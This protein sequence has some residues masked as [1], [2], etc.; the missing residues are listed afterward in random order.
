MATN[1]A[2][3]GNGSKV[4]LDASRPIP[5]IAPIASSENSLSIQITSFILNGCN[6]LYWFWSV[7]MVICGKGKIGSLD[8]S[9]NQPACYSPTFLLSDI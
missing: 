8:G 6:F 2:S 9:V 4:S 3:R 5:T 1:E 7:Q